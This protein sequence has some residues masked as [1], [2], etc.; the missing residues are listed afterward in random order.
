M[1]VAW[2]GSS[3]CTHPFIPFCTVSRQAERVEQ[4]SRLRKDSFSSSGIGP[5]YLELTESVQFGYNIT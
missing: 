2:Y 1:R 5:K 4:A 3:H